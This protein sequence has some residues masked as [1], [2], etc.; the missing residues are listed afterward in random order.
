MLLTFD[1][2][3]GVDIGTKHEIYVLIRALAKAGAAILYYTTEIPELVNICDR[4]LVMYRGRIVKELVG[5]EITEQAIMGYALGA[6]G[7]EEGAEAAPG[8]QPAVEAGAAP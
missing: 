4:V 6:E 7:P 3:R 1:P 5:D 8:P 2:T